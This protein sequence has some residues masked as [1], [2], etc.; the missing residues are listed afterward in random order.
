M[1]F[2]RVIRARFPTGQTALY[3]V[4]EQDAAKAEILVAAKVEAGL[5]WSTS[6]MPP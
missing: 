6:A 5:S 3:V 2:G 4:A 1:D